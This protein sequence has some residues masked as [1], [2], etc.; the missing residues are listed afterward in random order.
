[1]DS[2]KTWPG[3]KCS[4]VSCRREVIGIAK[5]NTSLCNYRHYKPVFEKVN[6]LVKLKEP[7]KEKKWKSERLVNVH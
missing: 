7:M 3:Q 4:R 5:V 6:L 1:M 2:I